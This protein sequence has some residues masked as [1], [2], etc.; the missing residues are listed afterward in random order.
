MNTQLGKLMKRVLCCKSFN[1][2][3]IT[4]CDIHRSILVGDWRA[5]SI[6]NVICCVGNS[7][8]KFTSKDK[9]S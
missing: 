9:R 4:N 3:T 8:L 6:D 2:S 5:F 7:M 1:I